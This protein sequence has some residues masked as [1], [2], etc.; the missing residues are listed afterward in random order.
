MNIS[1]HIRVYPK[2]FV[3]IYLKRIRFAPYREEGGASPNVSKMGLGQIELY[4]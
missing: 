2:A 1:L 4:C 3:Q